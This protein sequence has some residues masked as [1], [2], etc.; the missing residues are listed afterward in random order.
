[1]TRS[2]SRSALTL[3]ILVAAI[4]AVPSLVQ[5]Q[6]GIYVN[7][8]SVSQ[9]D[10]ERELA[11]FNL[12]LTVAVPDGR[13]WYDPVSGLWGVE[14]GPALGQMPPT[15][16]IGG[17]LRADASAGNTNIHVNGRELHLT[18]AAYLQQ[19]F[20]YVVPGRYWLNAFGIGGNEGG[21][22]LFNLAALAQQAGGSYTSR[23]P[24]GSIGSDGQCSYY[25][26]PGGTSVMSGNC[27]PPLSPPH[28]ESNQSAR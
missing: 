21:P 19:L 7:G 26:T 15:L 13:Y 1:M 8:E 6:Q 23:G 3:T 24:F 25:M 16:S 18:E 11:R 4:A 12:P 20:G 17:D 9:D 5:A 2:I 28:P 22:A 27:Q 10:F 14:G